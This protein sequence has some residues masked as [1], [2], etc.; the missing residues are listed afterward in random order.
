MKQ[1]AYLKFE[2]TDSAVIVEQGYQTHK[3]QVTL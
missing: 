1:L 2:K 3:K